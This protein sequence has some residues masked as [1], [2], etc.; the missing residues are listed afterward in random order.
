LNHNL[1]NIHSNVDKAPKL[2]GVRILANHSLKKS[3]A[4]LLL[5]PKTFNRSRPKIQMQTIKI[6]RK[7]KAGAVLIF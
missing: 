3:K 7:E 2:L 4:G 5:K 6:L 1:E